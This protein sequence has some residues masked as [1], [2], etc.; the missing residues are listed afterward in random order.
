MQSATPKVLLPSVWPLPVSLAATSGISF[1]F[2]SSAY[3]DVSV[4]R[5][6]L[7]IAI[8]FTIQ[9]WSIA[10]VGSPIRKSTDLWIFAPPRSLSQLVTSFFG[11][12]CQ[13]IRRMLLLAWP[14]RSSPRCSIC[15]HKPSPFSAPSP[16]SKKLDGVSF[17]GSPV[18]L[19]VVTLIAKRSLV[20]LEFSFYY[21][22]KSCKVFRYLCVCNTFSYPFSIWKN[23]YFFLLTSSSLFSF[24]SSLKH[25]QM[26]EK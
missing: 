5:V 15:F 23:L 10:P 7:H 20:L 12:W 26:F 9:Y 22:S 2:S 6:S 16:L 18:L 13:G 14:R 11:S 21:V 17:F 25:H 1:D 24:Q 4:Q 19:F 3:L 8:L